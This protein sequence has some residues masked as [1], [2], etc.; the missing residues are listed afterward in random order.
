M[1]S[2]KNLG[3]VHNQ[4][5]S[6]YPQGA[7]QNETDNVDGTPV[8]NEVYNDTLM[9]V[10]ALLAD[11]KVNLSNTEDNE[12]NGYQ[13]IKALK[14]VFN[15]YSDSVQILSK[16]SANW[17]IDIDSKLLPEKAV[18]FVRS[19]DNMTA[20]IDESLFDR[21][22]EY[23]KISPRTNVKTGDDCVLI[24]DS[25]GGRIYSLNPVSVK[26]SDIDNFVVYGNP[27]A[28]SNSL[29]LVWYFKDGILSNMQLEFYNIQETIRGQNGDLEL[30]V[31][32][33]GQIGSRF[34]CLVYKPSNFT[35]SF[36]SFQNGNFNSPQPVSIIGFSQ[37]ATGTDDNQVNIYFQNDEVYATNKA[38]NSIE[39]NEIT[40]FI[41][42]PQTNTLIYQ[43]NF[44]VD[45]DFEK[46]Q[47]TVVSE[48][49]LIYLNST[50][51]ISYDLNGGKLIKNTYNQLIGQLFRV[52]ANLY[53]TNGYNA[54][55]INI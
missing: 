48:T 17:F 39:N 15:E 19:T 8:V 31:K 13:I 53:F 2:L 54:S 22:G 52:G 20:N 6:L 46:N 14:L 25:S 41:F 45:N 7:I 12:V 4:N 30:E 51:I 50:G 44:T 33:V 42:N 38:G 49:R 11:R 34:L 24:Y 27:I 43:L 55:R 37:D 40:K 18:L 3:L 28:Q 29:P 26:E 1:R 5:Y 32:N 9:N 21:A 47:N 16:P 36:V 10:Y 35:Y 23:L